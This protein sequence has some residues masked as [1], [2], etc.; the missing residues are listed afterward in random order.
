MPYTLINKKLDLKKE[1]IAASYKDLIQKSL[2]KT[3]EEMKAE[4]DRGNKKTQR[5]IE[6]SADKKSELLITFLNEC[7]LFAKAHKEKY[8]KIQIEELSDT[9]IKGILKGHK[10]GEFDKEIHSVAYENL[11]QEYADDSYEVELVYEE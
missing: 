10:V 9:K 5:S 2:I 4:I 1:I 8:Y 6:V 7:I 3:M 11:L